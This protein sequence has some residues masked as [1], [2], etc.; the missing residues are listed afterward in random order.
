MQKNLTA[1]S[2][3]AGE[4]GACVIHSFIALLTKTSKGRKPYKGRDSQMV[5]HHITSPQL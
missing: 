1:S 2:T 3:L 4:Y 5:T